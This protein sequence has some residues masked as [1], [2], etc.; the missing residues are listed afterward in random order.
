MARG[1]TAT[2][3]VLLALAA[4]ATAG[5]LSATATTEKRGKTEEATGFFQ[6]S[7]AEDS[8]GGW[9]ASFAKRKITALNKQL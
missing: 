9:G 3:I 5:E 6:K 4:V 1:L 7:V 2:A 8:V